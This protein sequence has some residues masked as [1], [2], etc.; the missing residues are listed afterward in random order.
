MNPAYVLVG[1]LVGGVV[2]MTSIGMGIIGMAI[3]FSIFG[4]DP[5]TVVASNMLFGTIM[6]SIATMTHMGHDNYDLRYIPPVLVG[7]IPGI[8]VGAR[9]LGA[10]PEW[11]LSQFLGVILIAA[12]LSFLF[13][14]EEKHQSHD[15]SNFSVRRNVLLVSYFLLIGLLMGISS[16]GGPFIIIA[17]IH[18]NGLEP[19]KAVGT[20]LMIMALLSLP[21]TAAFISMGIV[22]YSLTF[23]LTLG[24]IPGLLIG[25]HYCL[26]MENRRIN[27]AIGSMVALSGVKLMLI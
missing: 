3:L 22:D 25:S 4:I 10:L 9:L 15:P 19:R 7:G 24:A 6:K 20:N 2:G 18:I 26:T 11:L 13:K 14:K 23:D 8:L 1:F 17:L 16:I 12:A 5:R 21:A 27:L